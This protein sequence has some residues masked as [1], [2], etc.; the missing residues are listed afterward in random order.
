LQRATSVAGDRPTWEAS[1]RRLPW[2]RGSPRPGSKPDG[3]STARCVSCERGPS[4]P[5][6]LPS[7]AS[8]RGTSIPG[9]WI[10][11][12]SRGRTTVTA[13]G[14]TATDL[15]W[16]SSRVSWIMVMRYFRKPSQPT[17]CPL[18]ACDDE[19]SLQV[20]SAVYRICVGKLLEPGLSGPADEL[21]LLVEV[22]T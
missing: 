7:D 14:R 10:S 20:S 13:A 15:H 12:P 6:D 8:R 21:V 1:C 11:S 4:R 19:A 17:I 5:G 18:P 3:A 9:R 16:M 22:A 2:R